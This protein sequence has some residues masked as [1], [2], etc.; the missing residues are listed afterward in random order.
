MGRFYHT[1]ERLCK[2]KYAAALPKAP[3]EMKSTTERTISVDFPKGKV[4]A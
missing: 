1:E 3:G 2:E 4:S